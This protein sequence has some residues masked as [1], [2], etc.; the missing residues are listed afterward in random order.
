MRG[1]PVLC[2][3]HRPH[4]E[5]GGPADLRRA[6][7]RRLRRLLPAD[8]VLH[9]APAPFHRAQHLLPPRPQGD[10]GGDPLPGAPDAAGGGGV[11]GRAVAGCARRLRPAAQDAGELPPDRVS[12]PQG[13]AIRD[14]RRLRPGAHGAGRAAESGR[15]RPPRQR[16][17]GGEMTRKC[18]TGTAKAVPVLF[19]KIP[20]YCEIIPCITTRY[21]VYYVST[22]N[23]IESPFRGV[24]T[25][26]ERGGTQMKVIKR[27]GSE[28]IFDITKIIMAITKANES[29]EEADRLT[30]VQIQRL[31]ESVELQCQ[32]M[33]RAPTVEEIQD[34]VENHIMAHGAF[35]VAKHP[36]I[37]K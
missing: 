25:E 4:P 22:Q 6:G 34:M 21:S 30:P 35:E 2:Q 28:V 20:L 27:N 7:H 23:G 32:K 17:G 37:I 24:H 36:N 9:G 16:P 8:A 13:A 3:P 15:L 12:A 10:L 26:R 19:A 29:V 11:R 1:E 5:G 14:R 18:P 31:A 33:G